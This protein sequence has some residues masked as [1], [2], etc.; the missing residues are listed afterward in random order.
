[1]VQKRQIM[2]LITTLQSSSFDAIIILN[3]ET[4]FYSDPR[5]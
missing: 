5:R 4:Y 1:M 2:G 3:D